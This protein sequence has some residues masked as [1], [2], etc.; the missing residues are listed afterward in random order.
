M[1]NIMTTKIAAAFG[2]S[3][4]LIAGCNVCTTAHCDGGLTIEVDSGNGE[5]LPSGTYVFIMDAD[6]VRI[7]TTCV[8]G[9]N[10]NCESNYESD[11]FEVY[12]EVNGGNYFLLDIHG[13]TTEDGVEVQVGPATTYLEVFYE[14]D[15]IADGEYTPEYD[16]EQPNGASCGPTCRSAMDSLQLPILP[17]GE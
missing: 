7:E 4:V 17:T 16:W 5:A 9:E 3:A 14:G 8:V 12:A 1:K 13:Y 6:G 15:G 10:Q 2:L 11:A